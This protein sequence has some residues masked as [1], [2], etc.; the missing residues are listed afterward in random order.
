[1]DSRI[2]L[3]PVFASSNEQRLYMIDGF[4]DTAGPE[5]SF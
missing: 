3:G 2:L 5:I 1:M 4:T